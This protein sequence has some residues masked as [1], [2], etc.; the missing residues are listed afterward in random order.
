MKCPFCQHVDTQV[1][2]TRVSEEGDA[3]RRRRRCA[4]CDKRFTTYERI[5]LSMPVI[6][7][8]NGN[9]TDYDAAKLRASL[10]LALRKRPV[11]AEA[12]DAAILRIEEKLLSSGLREIASGQV[13]EL[14]M[15]ELQRLDKIAYIRFASVYRNFADVAEFQEAIAEVGLERKPPAGK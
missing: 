2:D 4:S 3:I 11:S 15:Q 5:E 6:V 12:V 1:L 13:G 7:K 8:K 14:V 10:A 9:R